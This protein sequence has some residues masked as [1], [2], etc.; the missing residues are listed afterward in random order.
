VTPK[1]RK[2]PESATERLA[3]LLTMVP[4]L[5]RR[6]GIDIEEAAAQLSVSRAQLEADLSLLF[7][8]GTPGGMPDDLIE[9]DWEEGRVYLANADPISRPLRLGRDEALALIVGLRTL[10]AIPGLTDRDALDR[11]LAKLEEAVSSGASDSVGAAARIQVDLSEGAEE[12]TLAA[13]R[14]A[15]ARGRR[16][17]LSYLV[18]ARDEATERDVDP[19]R[20]LSVDGRWYVEGWCHRSEGVRLFRLDRIDAV[21]VLDEPGVAPEGAVGRDLDAG[22]FQPGPD[23]Q[24]VEIEL[25]SAARWVADYYPHVSHE[26][27]GDG[28]SR[29][30]LRT[31]DTRWLRRLLWRL[32]GQ[33]RIVS[34]DWLADE[35]AQGARAALAGYR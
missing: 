2:S 24:L 35:I 23:D 26:D 16:L 7:L 21:Q 10:G 30:R 14:D 29:L 27:C 34:P 12:R 33:A 20:L 17:H 5:L 6:Q 19:M 4:W 28:T 11:T 32:G 25:G 13:V 15:L 1:R 9:A 31:A 3:R 22:L 8:C 18:P